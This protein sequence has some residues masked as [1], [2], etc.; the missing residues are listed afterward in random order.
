M[1]QA[2]D[3]EDLTSII[4][5]IDDGKGGGSMKRDLEEPSRLGSHISL[6]NQLTMNELSN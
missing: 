3:E 2:L 4:Q 6:P 1:Y 5:I